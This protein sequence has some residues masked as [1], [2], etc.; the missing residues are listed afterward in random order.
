MC[1]CEE[2]KRELQ[3]RLQLGDEVLVGENNIWEV[4]WVFLIIYNIYVYI[5]SVYICMYI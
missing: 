5:L 1:V 4:L 2:I 3:V